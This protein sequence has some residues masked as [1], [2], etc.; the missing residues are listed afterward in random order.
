MK[1]FVLFILNVAIGL[2]LAI[3]VLIHPALDSSAKITF[4][5]AAV[6]FVNWAVFTWLAFSSAIKERRYASAAKPLP[7]IPIDIASKRGKSLLDVTTVVYLVVI[8]LALVCL[9]VLVL[10]DLTK[11]VYVVWIFAAAIL[12]P[13]LTTWV[14]NKTINKPKNMP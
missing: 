6:V 8:L 14:A 7:G 5:L 4:L 1:K 12:L 3:Q 10:L 11:P 9:N 2:T 13:L